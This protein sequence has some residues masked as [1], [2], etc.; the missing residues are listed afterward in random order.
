MILKFVMR[1]KNKKKN[2]FSI[3]LKIFISSFV[4]NM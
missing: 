3:N 1:N 2:F 4:L